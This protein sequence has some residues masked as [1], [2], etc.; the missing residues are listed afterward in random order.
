MV[1]AWQNHLA[2]RALHWSSSKWPTL[3]ASNFGPVHV[4]VM[5]WFKTILSRK[6]VRLGLPDAALRE[7]L[8]L[9]SMILTA[10][11]KPEGILRRLGGCATI[12]LRA[13]AIVCDGR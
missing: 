6:S 12:A 9:I 4:G 10:F 1:V 13:A 5:Q 11:K 8:E 7:F 3:K 2:S